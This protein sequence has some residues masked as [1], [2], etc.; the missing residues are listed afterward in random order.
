MKLISFL[1]A[2]LLAL[3]TATAIAQPYPAGPNWQHPQP[4]RDLAGEASA[5][6]KQGLE[7]MIQ[8]MNAKPRPT[9]MKLAAFLE[10]QVVPQFDFQRM[11][12]MAMGPA[13]QRLDEEK[14][15]DLEQQIEQH[16]LKALV[17]K[18]SR[19][20]QQ[21]IQY[22]RPR[23]S[24]FNQAVVTVG[25]ANPGGYPSRFDF[26]L[27]LGKDGWKIFD[28]AAN[29]QSVVAFYRRHFNQPAWGAPVGARR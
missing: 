23:R 20:E 4:Q 11:A 14:A 8:F 9:D 17:N 16:F 26:R 7:G 24:G 27:R 19:F 28:V 6:I 1:G 25:I 3:G 10:Q 22:F 2:A 29:G 21:Q 18:L 15:A 12:Q 5:M 13:Y